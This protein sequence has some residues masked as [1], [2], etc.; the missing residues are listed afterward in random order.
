MNPG[1]L[2]E[3]VVIQQLASGQD[4]IGQPVETWTTVAT[5]WADIRHQRGL[6]VIQGGAETSVVKASVRIRYLADVTAAM[7][8]LDGTEIYQIKSV[9]PDSDRWLDLV[10]EQ[11]T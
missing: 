2:S 5:V 6:E 10:C 8:L 7:R 9:L 1:R 11:V 3:R 4:A